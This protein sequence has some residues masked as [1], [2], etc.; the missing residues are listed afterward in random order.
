MKKLTLLSIFLT[1][2]YLHAVIK[3]VEVYG[4]ESNSINL[5]TIVPSQ[6]ATFA[7]S[8]YGKLSGTSPQPNQMKAPPVSVSKKGDKVILS[9]GI[10]TATI[11][12]GA[13]IS[14]LIYNGREMC[15]SIYYSMDG[16]TNYRTPGG[17]DF[18]VK[19]DTPDLVDVGFKQRG[20][21]EPQHMDCEIHYVL[22]RGDSGIYSYAILSH[23]ANYPEGGYGEWRFVWKHPEGLFENI[24]VDDSRHWSMPTER[25]FKNAQPTAIKEITKLTSGP[26]AGKYD[27]KYDYSVSYHD[28]GCWGHASDRNRVG[29]WM[30]LGGYDYLNDGP[31]KQDLSAAHGYVLVHFGRDHYNGSTVTAPSGQF[32]E[33]IFG[34]FLIYCNSSEQGADGCWADAKGRV[35]AEKAVWPYTWMTDTPLYPSVSKRG[36]IIG[37]LVIKDEIKSGFKP[38]NTWIG[39]ANPPSLGNWQFD[40]MGYQYWEKTDSGGNFTISNVRS[41]TYTLY[42]FTDGAVG[43]YSQ[44]NIRVEAGKTN[45]LGA[46]IWSVP[47]KGKSIAWEIGIPDRTS[48]EFRHGMDAIRDYVWENFQSEFKNPLE[49]TVG[50]SDPSKDWNYAQSYYKVGD[51][52]VPWKWRIHFSLPKT[53]PLGNACLTLAFASAHRSHVNVYVN[54]EQKPIA[55]VTPSVQGGDALLRDSNHAKYCVEYLDFSTSLLVEGE[56]TIT[57]EQTTTESQ[58]HVM[59]DY[60]NLELP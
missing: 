48:K 12:A 42:A 1:A 37:H 52:R 50:K 11:N 54:N 55:M 6:G 44:A 14:S 24:Y 39:L 43:E 32:W 21:D 27:C 56:N 2:H 59:Y 25:D 60:I 57:L 46:V 38:T 51:K 36:A 41:G 3:P 29:Q 10:L 26:W 5:E 23:P 8:G 40:S 34:P 47:H 7:A 35:A 31:T 22:K 45:N 18:S 19:T 49:Y 15:S 4:I 28:I 33:K 30:I 16:G 17:G 13:G 9:N 58:S 53:P 20:K